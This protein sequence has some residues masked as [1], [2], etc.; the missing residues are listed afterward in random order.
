M[1]P[2][3]CASISLLIVGVC[4]SPAQKI[5]VVPSQAMVDQPPSVIITGLATLIYPHAGHRSGLP[6][7]AP[8]WASGVTQRISGRSEE[9]GGSPEGNAESSLHATPRVLDFLAS[10]LGQTAPPTSPNP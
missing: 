9:F 4:M 6:D 2:V 1:K 3:C 8:T 7:I 10:N 5:Q